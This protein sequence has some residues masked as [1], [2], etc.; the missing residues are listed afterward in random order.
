MEL[1]DQR[2]TRARRAADQRSGEGRRIDNERRGW[3]RRDV[4]GERLSDGGKFDRRG[5]HPSVFA[6]LGFPLLRG[7]RRLDSPRRSG[8]LRR[9]FVRRSADR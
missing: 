4:A 3:S 1:Q 2:R 7:V 6:Q 9:S 8:V 5:P